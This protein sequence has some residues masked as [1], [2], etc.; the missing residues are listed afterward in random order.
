MVSFYFLLG[1]VLGY[2]KHPTSSQL[3]NELV[4]PMDDE[5]DNVLLLVHDLPEKLQG[6]AWHKGELPFGHLKITNHAVFTKSSMLEH[7]Y[8]GRATIH[9]DDTLLL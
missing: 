7:A 9:T 3:T 5:G 8:Y 2:K 4:P 1:L 6:F